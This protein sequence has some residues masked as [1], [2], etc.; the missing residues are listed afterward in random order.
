MGKLLRDRYEPLEVVG[1]GGEGEVVRALDH[2]HGRAVALKIRRV[3][4]SDRDAVLAEARVLLSLRPHRHLPLVRDDFFTDDSYVMVFD[5]IDG[6][7]LAQVLHDRGVPGLAGEQA[8][9][10]LAEAA[11]ALDH[12]HR[13]SPAI[14]HGDVK[15]ANLIL[16]PEGSLALVDFGLAGAA[17]Y[18]NA[19]RGTRG[20]VAP[21]A[22]AGAP[23]TP[24]ADVYGLAA[25]AFALLTGE[26]PSG[27][28]PSWVGVEPPR[29]AALE[30]A[31]GQALALDPA[32]RPATASELIGRLRQAWGGELPR[33]T[34]SFFLTDIEGS[35]RLWEQHPDLMVAALARHD[36]LIFDAVTS[37]GGQLIKSKGEGDSS[38]SVFSRASDA[39]DAAVALQRALRDEP[40]PEGSNLKVRVALHAGD[41]E[42]RDGDYFGAEVNRAARLRAIA[43]GGQVVLSDS[44]QRQAHDHL[45]AGA[46]LVDLGLHRLK[47]LTRP[48]RVF[49]LTVDDLPTVFPPLRSLD[50]RRTNLPFE[51]TSFVGREAELTRVRDL[52][53]RSRLV[54][55][56][57]AG[58]SGKTRLA[59]RAAA[60]MIDDA[61]DGVWFVEF[62]RLVDGAAIGDAVAA[63]LSVRDEPGRPLLDTIVESIADRRMFL[64]LDNC[65]HVVADVAALVER[66]MVGASQLRVL[67]TS[68]ERLAVAGEATWPV[69]PLDV[70]AADATLAEIAASEAVT[71]FVDRA[72][73]VV[74][75]FGV[76]PDNAS[77]V[78]SI[79]DRLDGIPLAVELAAARVAS[80]T[81]AQ[82]SSRLD[83]RFRLL[84]GGMRTALPRHQTLRSL[85]EWS[86]DLLSEKERAL[87]RRLAV[88][89]GGLDLDVAEAVAA[90]DGIDPIEIA[91]LVAG[92]VDKSL[93][94]AHEHDGVTRY[95][96]LETLREY[97]EEQL[98]ATGEDERWHRRHLTWCVDLAERAAGDLRGPTQVAALAALDAE[99]DNLRSALEWALARADPAGARLAGLLWPWWQIRG[100]WDEALRFLERALDVDGTPEADRADVLDGASLFA[101]LQGDIDRG[102][103]WAME[104]VAHARAGGPSRTLAFALVNVAHAHL[105]RQDYAGGALWARQAVEAGDA[106][107]DVQ[108]ASIARSQ[109]GSAHFLDALPEEDPEHPWRLLERAVD[110]ARAAGD[111]W[112]T[113]WTLELLARWVP[114]E[115]PALLEEALPLAHA[116]GDQQTE[117]RIAQALAFSAVE[118]ADLAR[119]K[120]A[121]EGALAVAEER[122]DTGWLAATLR[123]LAAVE[124]L[125]G[126]IDAMRDYLERLG[127]VH[128][129]LH[130]LF[131]EQARIQWAEVAITDGRIGEAV[132][133][134]QTTLQNITGQ[135]E[136]WELPIVGLLIAVVAVH[137]GQ[138]DAG[139]RMWGL[140]ESGIRDAVQHQ[141]LLRVEYEPHAVEIEAAL[142]PERRDAAKAA[143]A[144]MSLDEALALG[145][146]IARRA[147]EFTNSPLPDTR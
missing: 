58:G 3:T 102:E 66:L 103:A 89:R 33:G 74:P 135:F 49:Q 118:D 14:V 123:H 80:L 18:R 16:R 36:A 48:E 91:D 145:D 99:H 61:P 4:A 90:G 83:D 132:E 19:E 79:C 115:A 138:A 77:D 92:L 113:A 117:A 133:L 27:G 70:P 8:L 86:H 141:G 57:G 95:R 73:G 35:T 119:M 20:F 82:I 6:T 111:P 124:R 107:G 25:T 76:T 10:W 101:L 23:V 97:G 121:L 136:G 7:D 143:G 24:A 94:L 71:L 75:S 110:D 114:G 39:L 28:R 30:A 100:L 93:L 32:R 2:Q 65:E 50:A 120:E 40:W 130:G 98:A 85:V 13:H 112:L 139:V 104:A 131:V 54:T 15:P 127:A 31:L 44:I 46:R 11:D 47:D 129:P 128:D 56:T 60:E 144:R 105:S 84:T 5:W 59:L 108:S 96:M 87:F 43:H 38:L 41:V 106:A 63:A 26:A 34:V 17:G 52:I 12:L 1:R 22:A 67:A 68:R 53:G 142:P 9:A 137:S 21:E 125:A 62:A 45:P 64:V 88:F 116:V 72:R 146:A 134:L 55:L 140:C 37:A 122:R 78:L 109:L 147:L 42:L 69:P 126:D 51:T 29:V 81:P